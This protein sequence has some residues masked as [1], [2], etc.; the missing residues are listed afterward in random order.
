MRRRLHQ[1]D[2]FSAFSEIVQDT[3]RDGE[4]YLGGCSSSIILRF[5]DSQSA[6]AL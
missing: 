3:G 4:G 1:T 5:M 6:F 2:A